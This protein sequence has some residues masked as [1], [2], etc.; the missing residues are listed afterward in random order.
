MEG[1]LPKI[2]YGYQSPEELGKND[3]EEHP[4]GEASDIPKIGT[5]HLRSQSWK[6]RNWRPLRPQGVIVDEWSILSGL[7]YFEN[8]KAAYSRSLSQP[9]ESAA[10]REAKRHF[11]EIFDAK[12]ADECLSA[13][14][15]ARTLGRVFSLPDHILSS[16]R[17]NPWRDNT[18]E[19][20]THSE[21][22]G[23]EFS[24]RFSK[25]KVSD[26]RSSP[27][28]DPELENPVV[29]DK[30]EP[31]CNQTSGESPQIQ[32]LNSDSR[33][34]K[35]LP[36]VNLTEEVI[37]TEGT[38]C[39]KASATDERRMELADADEGGTSKTK[40]SDPLEPEYGEEQFNNGPDACTCSSP[41]Q[42]DINI[43]T[44]VQNFAVDVTSDDYPP[45]FQS[46]Q[47][48]YQA[49]RSNICENLHQPSPVSVLESAISEDI[50]SPDVCFP[51]VQVEILIKP[52]KIH[53]EEVEDSQRVESLANSTSNRDENGTPSL[54]SETEIAWKICRGAE[55]VDFEYV[56]IL[57][58][59]SKLTGSKECHL[60]WDVSD[61]PLDPSIFFLVDPPGE[62]SIDQ[63][64]FFDC[65]NE[66]LLEI[67]Q[68]SSGCQGVAPCCKPRVRPFPAGKNLIKEVWSGLKWHLALHMQDSRT[69][70]TLV[71]RDLAKG[72]WW[73]DLTSDAQA[74]GV[75]IEVTLLED[76]IEETVTELVC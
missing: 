17:L 31:S 45:P 60:S 2:S 26:G 59:A 46:C 10:T 16:P 18:Y 32:E 7:N 72:S 19:V 35:G 40:F 56:R 63:L 69:L 44:S 74:L 28:P 39:P 14:P 29:F 51:A 58:E 67:S 23:F 42:V 21:H 68:R 55:E 25:E 53:F 54:T 37:K 34:S 75:D 62:V 9:R 47:P 64:L 8:K 13:R 61:Q 6:E 30:D 12:N 52:R 41:E 65:V 5:R 15:T 1:V 27:N 4:I 50:S 11:S 3:D 71:E 38:E 24:S 49:V 57:L 43:N 48:S 22:L 66:V 73:M 70:E 20:Q 36:G 33:P 76:L